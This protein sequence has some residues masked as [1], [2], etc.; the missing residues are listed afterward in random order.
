MKD[1]S[2]QEDDGESTPLWMTQSLSG[3]KAKPDAQL[4]EMLAEKRVNEC[5]TA[6]VL[7]LLSLGAV[8]A[9]HLEKLLGNEL[10]VGHS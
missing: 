7:R 2:C 5:T 8:K 3:L 4:F 10:K 9:A 1:A 6:D